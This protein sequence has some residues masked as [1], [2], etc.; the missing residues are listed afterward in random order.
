MSKWLPLFTAVSLAFAISI[1]VFIYFS[2]LQLIV[3]SAPE[4]KNSW[5]A[6]AGQS[7]WFFSCLFAAIYGIE[8]A[9]QKAKLHFSGAV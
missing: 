4:W 5:L 3:Y 7:L 2:G 1:G 6:I 8:Y 9:L